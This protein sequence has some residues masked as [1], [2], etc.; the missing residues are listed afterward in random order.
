M[1]RRCRAINAKR[2]WCKTVE[3]FSNVLVIYSVGVMLNILGNALYSL[4]L[5]VSEKDMNILTAGLW[6]LVG[7]AILLV[8]FKYNEK[9]TLVN[10]SRVLQGDL[11]RSKKRLMSSIFVLCMVIF[12]GS[13][14][15]SSKLWFW[16]MTRIWACIVIT[17]MYAL[18]LSMSC[19][20]FFDKK[21]GIADCDTLFL[22]L[23]CVS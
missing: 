14:L 16:V 4:K 6:L 2:K 8:C 15:L 11:R 19:L 21:R 22:F 23:G 17:D 20:K 3:I 18:Y 7:M 1:D 12:F 13:Q 10:G 9:I 5:I